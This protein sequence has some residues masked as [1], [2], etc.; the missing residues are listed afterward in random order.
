LS[1]AAT[2]PESA[3]WHWRVTSVAAHLPQSV[4][5]FLP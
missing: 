2:L 4:V 5:R 3:I 1:V